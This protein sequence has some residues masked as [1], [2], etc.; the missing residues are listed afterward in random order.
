MT[1]FKNPVLHF[2]P[3]KG[4]FG[5][6][7]PFYW[8][9][10]YHIFFQNS[11]NGLGFDGMAWGHIISEDLI[12]WERLPDALVPEENSPDAYGCWTGSIIHAQGHFHI[13][14]TGCAKP[15]AGW[16]T[17]CHATSD[18]LVNW[19]KDPANP[20]L[21]A[22]E[23]YA[24]DE[25]SAWRDP[26]VVTNGDHGYRMILSSEHTD[27]AKAFHG[28][29][30]EAFST[31]LH[32]WKIDKPFYAP[33]N[34]EKMECADY[35]TLRGK[36]ILIYS[37][38]GVQIR[39]RN[40]GAAL[41]HVSDPGSVDNYRYYAGKTLIDGNGRRLLFGF[42][43][44]REHAHDES[45]WVWGGI[46]AF[47]RE[48]FMD[49]KDRLYFRPAL[50][51]QSLRHE[52]LSFELVPENCISGSWTK[53][54][55][56]LEGISSN[57]SS[58]L[59]LLGQH[60]DQAEF[61]MTIDLSDKADAN[62][63]LH[64]AADL[65]QGYR[66]KFDPIAKTLSL[67]RLLPSS[68]SEQLELQS[69]SLPQDMSDQIQVTILLDGTLIEVFLNQRICFSARIYDLDSEVSYWGLYSKGG[70]IKVSHID[71]W[72]LAL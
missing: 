4:L 19:K 13:F 12:H 51:L 1:L 11:P 44:N 26:C 67:K 38:F 21:K 9:G 7:I 50:E 43:F 66:L 56:G 14:Y 24:A 22:S 23:P 32:D 64:C 71:L 54:S 62:V 27:P 15:N 18:D 25:K 17:I 8:Q 47:P 70:K 29:L 2:A 31:N 3:Q 16:Q 60:P 42:I 49:D 57:S 39:T 46:M 5:D 63:L 6:P 36:E 72:K 55:N 34:A 40:H 69:I 61:F 41:W 30:S 35:F 20:I 68:I 48:I 53:S 37:D 10:V 58:V 52:N 45:D 65:S 33:F 28:C 59:A